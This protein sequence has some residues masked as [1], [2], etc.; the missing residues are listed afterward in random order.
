[1][2]Q[3]HLNESPLN[4]L[5]DTRCSGVVVRQ[6]LIRPDQFTSIKT[7]MFMI[8]RSAISVPVARCSI[9]SAVFSGETDVLCVDNPI[10]DVIICNVEGVHTDIRGELEAKYVPI[11]HVMPSERADNE[12]LTEMTANIVHEAE[13]ASAVEN[14][15]QK[16]QRDKDRRPLCVPE[17]DSLNVS[18]D[19]FRIA[20][21]ENPILRTCFAKAQG[22]RL[23]DSKS[24]YFFKKWGLLNRHFQRREGQDEWSQ[25][26]VPSVYRKQ[27]MRIG[28]EAILSGHL[29]VKRTADQF[30]W[31]FFCPGMFGDVTRLRQSCDICQR[32]VNKGSVKVGP[33]QLMPLVGIPVEK[34]AIDLTTLVDGATR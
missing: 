13:I 3:D 19:S 10:Y 21:R 22:P 31:N 25:L 5:R 18:A 4:I 8:N 14:H 1:M 34:I 20:Q 2:V 7:I 11:I 6:D 26:V 12:T 16:V 30:F 24:S 27:I 32:A 29:G 23:G 17:A 33:V 9:E 28:H 15:S